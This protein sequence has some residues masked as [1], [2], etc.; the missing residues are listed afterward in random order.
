[1]AS[2]IDLVGLVFG[3]LTVEARAPNN[4]GGA[5]MWW[6][7]CTCGAELIAWG[8]DLRRGRTISCGC[9]RRDLMT[10]HGMHDTPTYVS[11]QTMIQ[12]CCNPNDQ[13]WEH[14]GGRGITVCERWL[15]FDGFLADMGERP[16][17]LEI[18]RIDNAGAYEPRNC[19]WATRRDQ[20]LNTRRQEK[21][22]VGVDRKRDGYRARYCGKHLGSFDTFEE[23]VAARRAAEALR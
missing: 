5:A 20:C 18:D 21:V 11:W 10:T 22:G 16:D 19:R 13:H 2:L 4:A 8:V 1:M 7:K 3:R 23:A 12:R 14:Y 6:C 9:Y 15:K 17:G